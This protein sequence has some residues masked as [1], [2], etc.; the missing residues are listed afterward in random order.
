MTKFLSKKKQANRVLLRLIEQ[1]KAQEREMNE[2]T[3]LPHASYSKRSTMGP[4]PSADFQGPQGLGPDPFI[5]GTKDRMPGTTPEGIPQEPTN[6]LVNALRNLLRIKPKKK[7]KK[8]PA[9][10]PGFI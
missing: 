2:L 1:Q 6:P 10:H 8:K 9:A 5:P 7:P 3:I 4:G